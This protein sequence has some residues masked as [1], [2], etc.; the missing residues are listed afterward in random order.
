MPHFN[1][2]IFL[3]NTG[4]IGKADVFFG[5][6]N[7]FFFSVKPSEGIKAESFKASKKF[8]IDTLKFLPMPWPMH[9]LRPDLCARVAGSGMISHRAAPL[10]LGRGVEWGGG[11]P[12]SWLGVI[13]ESPRRPLCTQQ[14]RRKR[15]WLLRARRDSSGRARKANKK[16]TNVCNARR[17][18]RE[19]HTG[20]IRIEHARERQDEL[21]DVRLSGWM[22]L[23]NW[24]TVAANALGIFLLVVV[25]RSR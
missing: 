10:M 16:T 23:V 24:A 4:E 13:F 6:V 22:A 8:Y 1:S 25:G 21:S 20:V 5:P 18:T 19:E 14:R 15:R 17:A 2:R 12:C 3:E 7:S 11:R 9:R